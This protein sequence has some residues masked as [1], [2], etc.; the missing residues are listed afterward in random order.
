[1]KNIEDE[2]MF[3][4]TK[5]FDFYNECLEDKI[6]CQN[7]L[8]QNVCKVSEIKKFIELYSDSLN[9][10]FQVFIPKADNEAYRDSKLV[11]MKK[12][13]LQLE[14]ENILIRKDLEKI[15]KRIFDYKQVL[16]IVQRIC[17]KEKMSSES[18]KEKSNDIYQL[19]LQ[20]LKTQ[21]TDRKRIATDIH[22]MPIQDL[23]AIIHKIELSRN[24]VDIDPIRTKLELV[25]I[26]K[27]LRNTIDDMRE[28]IY[29]LRPMSFDDIG[30]EV[31]IERML[32][33]LRKY[34]DSNIHYNVTGNIKKV[35]STIA[36]TIFRV[37]QEAVIN[38]IKHANAS[39]I[40]IDI[41]HLGE[42]VVFSIRDNGVGFD[43]NNISMEDKENKNH[44]GLSMMKENIYLLSGEYKISSVIGKGT[45]IEIE[46]LLNDNA[47]E[48]R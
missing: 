30:I 10:S 3:V 26:S 47:E 39:D 32:D 19:K 28:I 9:D 27:N 48:E 42:K 13:L 7:R 33:K 17:K 18:I 1:M 41:V 15:E 6:L 23:T 34:T 37:I 20:I 14:K 46:I 2:H 40:F 4:R 38:A 35:E 24:L 45:T 43:L 22:N 36:I 21:E 12:E 16:E 8:N 25:T 31:T 5:I 11:E 29:N 44:F